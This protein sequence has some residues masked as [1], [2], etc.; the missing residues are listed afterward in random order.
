MRTDDLD[1]EQHEQEAREYRSWLEARRSDR[2]RMM[3]VW[4]RRAEFFA[5]ILLPI[6]GL[7]WGIA[8]R[9]RD[10][11]EARVEGL[12]YLLAC[13][14]GMVLQYIVW[15]LWGWSILELLMPGAP[16]PI[17]RGH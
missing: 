7:V 8:Y 13:V 14:A 1:E 2:R 11:E 5:A 10:T 9:L 16:M 4:L 3:A 12:L 17:M 15:R 6:V